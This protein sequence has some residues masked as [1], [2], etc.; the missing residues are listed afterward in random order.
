MHDAGNV[1]RYQKTI[2]DCDA[3][4]GAMHALA[5]SNRQAVLSLRGDILLRV[6]GQIVLVRNPED[7]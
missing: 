6:D 3:A 5:V 7:C 1:D 4:D 2:L